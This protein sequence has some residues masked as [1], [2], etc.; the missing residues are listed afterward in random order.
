M[1]ARE[2]PPKS[3][4]AYI[5]RQYGKKLEDV[6]TDALAYLVLR[7][8][9]RHAIDGFL[10][11]RF[12]Y[13][14]SALAELRPAPRK[15]GEGGDIPD[16]G[17]IDENQR[18][19]IIFE[20]KLWSGLTQKQPVSYLEHCLRSEEDML[21]F[22]VPDSGRNYYWEKIEARCK[23]ELALLE[24]TRLFLAKTQGRIQRWVAVA[25]WGELV[26]CLRSAE[27]GEIEVRM[28]LDEMERSCEMANKEKIEP[29]SA[30]ETCSTQ[31]AKRVGNYMALADRIAAESGP[32]FDCGEWKKK[33][34]GVDRIGAWWGHYGDIGG[35]QV[36]IGVD[37]GLWTELSITPVWLEFDEPAEVERLGK[38]FGRWVAE[39]NCFVKEDALRLVFPI[40]LK[41]GVL[42]DEIVDD[43]IGQVKKIAKQLKGMERRAV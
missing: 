26:S 33:N 37:T 35:Y 42:E 24:G 3:F 14:F 16:I 31:V 15:R 36:W 25:S 2:A 6:V 4:F 17:F 5:A 7:R 18:C 13:R 27:E 12:D 32:D 29:L 30:S 40:G 28:L 38:V 10:E 9:I 21:L 39:K 34:S 11:S 8:G 23:G 43:A 41:S 22:I 19:R 1:S 20:S